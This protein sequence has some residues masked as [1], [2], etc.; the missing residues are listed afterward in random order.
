MRADA[1][2][3]RPADVHVLPTYFLTGPPNTEVRLT[4]RKA[5]R[6]NGFCSDQARASCAG[7]SM[8]LE[9]RAPPA[10]GKPPRSIAFAATHS[11]SGAFETEVLRPASPLVPGL[12]EVRAVE[13]S[14]RVE[15]AVIALFRVAGEADSVAPTW[16]GLTSARW[17][18]RARGVIDLECGS[19]LLQLEAARATDDMTSDVAINFAI[20]LAQPGVTIDYTKPPLLYVNADERN[21]QL[22]IGLGNTEEGTSNFAPVSTDAKAPYPALKLGVRAVD[23]AGNMSPPSEALVR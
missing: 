1:I 21:A 5:W 20:W 23:L 3:G 17:V 10:D 4:L 7:V 8:D 18:R 16:A 9:L 2:C 22:K 14:A 13:R 12:Y 11:A 6:T 19:P 15:P